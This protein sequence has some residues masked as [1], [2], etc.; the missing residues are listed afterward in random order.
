MSTAALADDTRWAAMHHKEP[1][2]LLLLGDKGPG[3]LSSLLALA[4]EG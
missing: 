2:Q 1:G 3:T 4:R